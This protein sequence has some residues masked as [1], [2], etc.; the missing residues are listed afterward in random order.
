MTD[1]ILKQ[2]KKSRKCQKN[3]RK[4]RILNKSRTK[5]KQVKDEYFIDKCAEIETLQNID[6]AGMH[7]KISSRTKNMHF[8]RMHKVEKGNS[9]NR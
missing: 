9:H 5:F 7:E 8:D 6:I 2:M 4:Y 1:G 3:G